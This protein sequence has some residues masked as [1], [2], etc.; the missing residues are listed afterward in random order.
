MQKKRTKYN[1]FKKRY[2]DQQLKKHITKEV[3]N[4]KFN[5]HCEQVS[6]NLG[7]DKTVVRELLLHNSF[8]VL[9]L[10]Q[11]NILKNKEVKINITGYFSLITLLIKFKFTHLRIKTQNKT[12]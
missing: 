6:I 3:D 8:L 2:T 9:S 12:Y 4:L 11:K 1:F 7:I 10:L 5:E